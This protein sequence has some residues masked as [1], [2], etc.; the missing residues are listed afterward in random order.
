MSNFGSPLT[1]HPSVADLLRWFQSTVTHPG[2]VSA[3]GN[4]AAVDAAIAPSSRQTSAERL[5]VY[6]Q[7]YWARLVGCLEEEFPTVRAAVGD[8]AFT[9]FTVGYIEAHPSTSYTLGR[10]SDRFVK[11]LEA[12]AA[13]TDTA[14]PH[15]SQAVVEIARLERAITEVFDAPGG[16]TLGYLTPADL[17]AIPPERQAELRLTPLPTVRLLAFD[18][19]VNEFFSAVRRGATGDERP[20]WPE[21]RPTY[22]A[23]SRRGFIVRRHALSHPEFV[24]L[25]GVAAGATL[26][27]ALESLFGDPTIDVE[28]AA[29]S[30]GRW[31]S[32]WAEAGLF[33]SLATVAE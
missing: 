31:F 25:A 21:R 33:H 12:T 27:G 8:E 20:P 16:E 1:P 28:A 14:D 30:L 2:G 7:S 11:Y 15:W 4:A 9:S 22:L 17:Q 32:D 23:L 10:L 5:T 13:A 26:S 3:E 29:A 19:D 24:L 18:H 6:A